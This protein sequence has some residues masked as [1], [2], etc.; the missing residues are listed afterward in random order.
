MKGTGGR[1]APQTATLATRARA[2]TSAPV[3]RWANLAAHAVPLRVLPSA[4]WRIGAWL[5]GPS[6][7]YHVTRD[8]P[9]AAYVL[10]LTVASEGLALLT[11][12]LVRPWGDVVPAWIPRL[13]GRRI[14][15]REPADGCLD[16]HLAT[17]RQLATGLLR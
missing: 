11:L 9:A 5:A 6:G 17:G 15:V 8:L 2:G 1:I 10:C 16:C 12:G 4:L 13:G 14:P 3:P 7:W